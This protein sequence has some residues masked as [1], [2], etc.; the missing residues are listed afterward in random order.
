MIT[1][2]ETNAI[3][4]PEYTD[5][6]L[7]RL[8]NF[9]KRMVTLYDLR[10]SDWTEQHEQVIVE[11]IIDITQPILSAYFEEDNLK[12][13]LG[14]PTSPYI[15]LCYFLRDPMDVFNLETFHDKIIF[16]T[17]NDN[18]EGSIL[19]VIEDVFA[20][21]FFNI[22][23]WPDSTYIK[24]CLQVCNSIIFHS[25]IKADFCTNMHLFLAKLTDLHHKMYGLTVIY[26][27]KEGLQ[28]TAEAASKDKDL[29][30]R[31]E[32]I[33]VYWTRQVRVG[34]QDTDQNTPTD[35]LCPNDEYEFWKYRC[36]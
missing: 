14:F 24:I 21:Y 30:K 32:S 17:V 2:E 36:K 10:E 19:S 8:I 7:S 9:I 18:I 6:E 12:V 11:Y 15:D 4:V 35:L 29:V 23:T 34:L 27:P 26:I 3:F 5:E 25:G 16:G 13:L 22:K 31:L 1:P 28:L 33:I 20:P